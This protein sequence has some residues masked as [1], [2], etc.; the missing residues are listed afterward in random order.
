MPTTTS[1]LRR[2]VLGATT[3]LA[4]GLTPALQAQTW[5]SKPVRVIVSFPPGGAADQIARAVSQPLQEALG[6]PVVV[7]NRA[8]AGGVTSAAPSALCAADTGQLAAMRRTA[9]AS[10]CC[11]RCALAQHAATSPSRRGMMRYRTDLPL[12]RSNAC[13]ISNTL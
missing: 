2:A 13:T 10:T 9:W 1:P 5:P 12:M 11:A 7:E 3:L 8:G 6:Q 4:L